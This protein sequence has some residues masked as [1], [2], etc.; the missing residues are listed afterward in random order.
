MH[1]PATAPVRR[2]GRL[3]PVLLLA[4]VTAVAVVGLTL[5]SGG[6][7]LGT[8]LPPL[9]AGWDPKATAWALLAALLLA[10]AVALGPRLLAVRSPAAFAVALLVVSLVVRLGVGAVREGPSG[11][12]AVFD[13]S[14][15][16][17]NEYLPAL[18]ALHDGLRLFLD[19]FAE[20]VPALP[21]HAAGHPPG[22]LTLMDLLGVDSPEGLAALVIGVGVLAAPLTYALGRALLDDRR[23]R[24]A[25][26]LWALSPM[27]VLYTVTS[28]DALYAT[29]GTVAALGL[30]GRGRL[31]PVAGAAGLA[32]ASFFGWALLGSGAWAVIVALRR[33]GLRRAA[34]LCVACAA[35]IVCF[36][37]ALYALTGYDPVGAL[38]ATGQVY[39]YS[40]ASIR[41]YAYWVLGSPAAFVIALGPPIAWYL[42]RSAAAARTA[43]LAL[44]AV[45]VVAS[46]AGFTKAETERIWLFMVPLACVA[47]AEVLPERRLRIVLAL[48]A[49]QTLATELLLG[50]VW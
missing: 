35:A 13:T 34:A 12:H 17:G 43:G 39:R 15:E 11:W 14:F 48:L 31:A 23:A 16:S 2:L 28:A 32:V 33:D 4:A 45:I 46:V 1:P 25:A 44:A 7:T 50:T 6:V 40:V 49:V 5:R 38:R 19:R 24:M 22:L 47:A 41:P 26:L 8:P 10:G 30:V 27:A 18:S 3:A 21:V 20:L 29:V 37:A 42:A 9:S 36:Y